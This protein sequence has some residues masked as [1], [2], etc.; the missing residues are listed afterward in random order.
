MSKKQKSWEDQGP[1]MRGPRQGVGLWQK[2]SPEDHVKASH[3]ARMIWRLV[4]GLNWKR[5]EERIQSRLA[6][7]RPALDPRVLAALWVY[8]IRQGVSSAR[9]LAR[10]CE[11]N[12][13]YIW[14]LG[15]QRTNHHSLSDFLRVDDVLLEDLMSQVIGCLHRAKAV[16]FNVLLV[17]GTKVQARAGAASFYDAAGLEPAVREKLRA[18]REKDREEDARVRAAEERAERELLA[19]GEEALAALRQRQA[20]YNAIGRTRDRERAARLKV[21][22]SD[23]EARRMR[24]ADGGVQPRV[25]LQLGV[26]ADVGAV[27]SVGVT[28]QANDV[29]LAPAVVRGM[30]QFCGVFPQHVLTDGGFPNKTSIA[31]LAGMGV[32][33]YG[34]LQRSSREG[35]VGSAVRAC[36]DRWAEHGSWARGLRWRVEGV[37]GQMKGRGLR[38]IPLFG[39][40]GARRWALWHGLTHNILLWA[41]G[42]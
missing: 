2:V 41:R 18:L 4:C 15:G 23:P 31:E 30:G 9:E 10:R 20:K 28:A 1:R 40:A 12:L 7:G 5:Y 38:R 17:D 35:A 19:R 22:L 34:P 42:R 3:P 16:S 36:Q 8:G 24:G 26:S 13:V 33:L 39:L 37:I 21:S 6:G 32:L 14:L 11:D 27:L 29:G 25:N